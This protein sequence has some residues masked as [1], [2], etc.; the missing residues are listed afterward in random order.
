M[1]PEKILLAD[2]STLMHKLLRAV[3]PGVPMVD[4]LDGWEAL[5][6]L[7]E[8]PDVDLMIVDINMPRM[9]GVELVQRLKAEGALARIPVVVMT[10]L[11][12]EH[13]AVTCL[14]AG[15]A[16]YVRKPFQPREMLD[17]VER[18]SPAGAVA[19]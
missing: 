19:A 11:G 15:A 8:H 5:S 6:R 17:I 18:L 14:R 1:K 16:A 10:T 9:D 13:D 7:T 12:K 4:A 3:L 2:D